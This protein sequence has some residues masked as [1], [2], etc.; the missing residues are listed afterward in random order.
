MEPETEQ[1]PNTIP[2]DKQE[3]QPSAETAE[4]TEQLAEEEPAR[5]PGV[6]TQPQQPNEVTTERQVQADI[7]NAPLEG[8]SKERTRQT[9]EIYIDRLIDSYV[10]EEGRDY[11]FIRNPAREKG[12]RRRELHEPDM[13]WQPVWV[14]LCNLIPGLGLAIMGQKR[15]GAH[16]FLFWLGL[17]LVCLLVSLFLIIV[18]ALLSVTIIFLPFTIVA[19]VLAFA[20]LLVPLVDMVLCAIDGGNI[21][22]RLRSGY[23]V[24]PGEASYGFVRYFGGQFIKPSFVY[25]T[26]SSKVPEISVSVNKTA[27]KLRQL[28]IRR[29]YE[30]R[31]EIGLRANHRGNT[32]AY[33]DE[34]ERELGEGSPAPVDVQAVPSAALDAQPQRETGMEPGKTQPTV[35]GEAPPA[36]QTVE[37]TS[38]P[39]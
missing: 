15:R 25:S 7:L 27:I 37:P 31:D 36:P 20:V 38:G 8:M 3:A 12:L 34:I 19:F 21:A 30:E 29:E 18:G 4:R 17:I 16:Y 10:S 24:M 33:L 23:Y 35:Q 26:T 5:I 28:S 39:A 6:D 9:Y 1:Q 11:P 13:P 2:M 14:G 22:S 32:S